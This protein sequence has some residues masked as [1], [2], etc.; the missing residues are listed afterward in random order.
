MS[1]IAG[2]QPGVVITFY[3]YKGGV[4]RTFLLGNVAAQLAKWGYRVLC[5]DWDLEAPG[6]ENYFKN[7][8]KSEAGESGLLHLLTDHESNLDWRNCVTRLNLKVGDAPERSLDLIKSGED[9]PGYEALLHETNWDYLYRKEKLGSFLEQLREDWKNEYDFV[10]IDSRTGITDIGGICT[11]QLP[12]VLVCFVAA[13]EQNFH[14]TQAVIERVRAARNN[15]AFDR[16]GLLVVPI[17]SRF[18]AKEEYEQAL[19][20]KNRFAHEFDAAFLNWKEK[21]LSSRDLAEF[22]TVPYISY[23]SFGERL[24]V[25]E[26]TSLPSAD[27][28]VFS[29]QTLAALLAHNLSETKQLVFERDAYVQ[30][31]AR[32]AIQS[33]G[34]T[35][36]VY[37]SYNRRNDESLRAARLL[38]HSLERQDVSVFW[39]D[40][41]IDDEKA[42]RTR[43]T[44]HLGRA[45]YLALLF[46]GEFDSRQQFEFDQ[47][48]EFV[49]DEEEPRIIP[50]IMG[51]F[52]WSR[53]QRLLRGYIAQSDSAGTV[54]HGQDS[55]DA[56]TA[57]EQVARR[58][59]TQYQFL[60]SHSSRDSTAAQRI[61]D[62]LANAGKG[63]CVVLDHDVLARSA[64]V[65]EAID[66]SQSVVLLL[67]DGYSRTEG[68]RI[69]SIA[70]AKQRNVLLASLESPEYDYA[71]STVKTSMLEL[72]GLSEDEIVSRILAVVDS[73]QLLDGSPSF[74]LSETPKR[75]AADT[76]VDSHTAELTEKAELR[77]ATFHDSASTSPGKTVFAAAST[78]GATGREPA[79][80]PE[81]RRSVTEERER[82]GRGMLALAWKS[83][84][85][86][87]LLYEVDALTSDI[88]DFRIKQRF[89]FYEHFAVFLSDDHARAVEETLDALVF[90]KYGETFAEAYDTFNPSPQECLYLLAATRLRCIGLLW[91]LFP[92]RERIAPTR[93]Y[94]TFDNSQPTTPFWEANEGRVDSLQLQSLI[95]NFPARSSEF[96]RGYWHL[97]CSWSEREKDILCS[98]LNS[99]LPTV[100]EGEIPERIGEVRLRE[101]AYLMR[102]GTSCT[103]SREVCPLE[104]RLGMKPDAYCDVRRT[105]LSPV[106]WIVETTFDHG[107][108]VFEISANIPAIQ[109][110]P[111][112]RSEA[113]LP[114]AYVDYAPG[115]EF[116]GTV[117]QE[118]LDT[119][120]PN[121]EKYRNTSIR[122]VRVES[123]HMA[124]DA[125]REAEAYLPNHWA[126]PL[127]A[128][129]NASEV[130]GM[131]ALVLRSFCRFG[132]GEDSVSFREQVAQV[133]EAV[134][135]MHPCNV[136]ILKLVAMIRDH[137]SSWGR[138]PDK[139]QIETFQKF[140]DYYLIERADAV[141]Q[142]AKDA[143][144]SRVLN[145]PDEQQ[146]DYVVVYGYGRCVLSTLIE[147]EFRG[148][149]LL[150]ELDR[151]RGPSV[152]EE[153]R[154][155][156]ETL[157]WLNIDYRNVQLASL[158]VVLRRAKRE[159]MS[160]VFL[161]E[162][163]AVVREEQANDEFLCHV[164]TWQVGSVVNAYG[165]NTIVLAEYA[166]VVEDACE[167]SDI[168]QSL[169]RM[170]YEIEGKPWV[171]VD[172]LRGRVDVSDTVIG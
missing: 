82:R 37:I 134:E 151:A 120:L 89:R 83:V 86:K 11:V 164:G 127:A 17:L 159:G 5:I 139:E 15:V 158:P 55:R 23:W 105:H 147:S 116:L 132:F 38:G 22:L 20:W 157:D 98:L 40:S 8:P 130:A 16:G 54:I 72:H 168:R 165:G 9:L 91:G 39:D 148:E 79:I 56:D 149:I 133:C 150:I 33:S 19:Q 26:E 58:V 140:L 21:N 163:S 106:D 94:A 108:N 146:V 48:L 166:K 30:T 2:N 12:D 61:A 68:K 100:P 90:G 65:A 113:S 49:P 42:M 142:V 129:V 4:G 167:I 92:D 162:T 7:L 95:E 122:T 135:Q 171:Q 31:A 3:S 111:D 51:D 77:A 172:V 109:E 112:P 1:S 47:F 125:M 35:Y 34:R 41:A 28:I 70:A 154:R 101:L 45:R 110:I 169:D 114:I 118:V 88:F 62:G 145:G 6:L 57:G 156:E 138:E 107:R 84:S 124:C 66:K 143:V 96:V 32:K 153:S 24:P 170:E 85:C 78:V 67:S 25:V 69:L 14:G 119:A 60:L 10:L 128:A 121:L 141:G 152:N 126:L 102:V 160:F 63:V 76:I 81:S 144:T 75:R 53:L 131:T 155:I 44:E 117:I 104:I 97:N 64:H 115:L 93:G 123:Y 46:L 50:I 43:A 137:S 18:D 71:L 80:H 161:T 36:D 29:I 13:N 74:P 103:I 52:D 87:Q 136:L 99:C 73:G 27:S 59:K